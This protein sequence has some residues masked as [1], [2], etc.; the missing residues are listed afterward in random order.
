MRGLLVACLCAPL[1]LWA[2]AVAGEEAKPRKEKSAGGPGAEEAGKLRA[3][4][5]RLVK[6]LGDDDYSRRESAGKEL[7][8]IGP[9]A[10]EALKAAAKDKDAERASRAQRLLAELER[11]KKVD[12]KCTNGYQ[13]VH[14]GLVQVQT[15]KAKL[16]KVETVRVRLARTFSVPAAD[17]VVELRDPAKKNGKPLARAVF[18]TDWND[19]TGKPPG[20]KS[21]NNLADPP[22]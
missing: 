11:M 19:W 3:R 10:R 6:Q 21:C 4:I 14:E 9:P 17:L 16:E 12:P 7:L 20:A 18:Y 8:K 22:R 5:A 2:A 15:F 13:P 1:L